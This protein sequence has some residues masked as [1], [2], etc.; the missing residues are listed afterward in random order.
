MKELSV[1]EEKPGMW[2]TGEWPAPKGAIRN[3]SS[4][5]QGQGFQMLGCLGLG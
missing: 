1:E 4:E 5:V 3:Q 2:A